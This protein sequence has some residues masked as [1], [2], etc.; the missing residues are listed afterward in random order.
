MDIV[1]LSKEE[2]DKQK[3]LEFIWSKVDERFPRIQSAF[4]F[5]DKNNN[6]KVSLSEFQLAIETLRVKIT[7][8]EIKQAFEYLD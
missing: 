8:D 7:L 5:F 3:I 6:S 4:W 2:V 1:K